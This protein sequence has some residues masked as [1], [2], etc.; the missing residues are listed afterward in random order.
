M[1]MSMFS[2][3]PALES[4]RRENTSAFPDSP[5]IPSAVGLTPRRLTSD[6]LRA[7]ARGSLALAHRIDSTRPLP[8]AHPAR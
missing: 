3:A 6:V 5:T 2:I 7:I 4:T 1:S 8:A